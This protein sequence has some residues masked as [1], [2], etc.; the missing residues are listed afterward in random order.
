MESDVTNT[1]RNLVG[2]GLIGAAAGALIWWLVMG[3]LG[4][5][6]EGDRPPI[7]ISD[8]SINLMLAGDPMKIGTW[9]GAAGNWTHSYS[10]PYAVDR[11]QLSIFNAEGDNANCADPSYAFVTRSLTIAGAGASLTL[12]I[13]AGAAVAEFDGPGG[14]HKNARFWLRRMGGPIQSITFNNGADTTPTICRFKGGADPS[15][16]HVLQKKP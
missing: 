9:E 11:F 15:V 4:P 7:I 13:N 14:W 8:G 10:G 5:R 6:D 12:K 3:G 1:T 16:V 2:V